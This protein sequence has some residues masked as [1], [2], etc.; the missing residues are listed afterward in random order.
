MV[1]TCPTKTFDEFEPEVKESTRTQKYKK[2]IL[3]APYEICIERARYFTQ[4]YKETEGLHPSLRAAKAIEKT[5]DN[6]TIYIL[7]E[8]LL[9]GNRSSKLVASVIPIERGEF[10][11][12][13]ELDLNNILK[14]EKQPF[15]ISKEEKRELLK[16]ILP[17]WRGKDFRSDKL[18][19]F[20]ENNVYLIPKLSLFSIFR[21]IKNFGIKALWKT[22][23]PL[24]KGRLLHFKRGIRE[25]AIN[26]PNLV[27]DVFDDQ[28]HLILGHDLVMPIGYKGVKEQAN[29]LKE[30]NPDKSA[31]YDAV[32]ICCDAVRRFAERFSSLAL[33]I[34][35]EETNS[36]RREELIQ[37]SNNMK[38]VPWNPPEHFYEAVQFIWFSQNI[39]LI[40]FGLG[41]IFSIGRPDQYLY[42]YYKRDLEE[43][44]ISREFALELVEE[45]LIKL[46]Y[47]L[48]ILP[49]Y[50]K[51]TASEL[52]GDNN[53]VAVGGV[54]SEGKDAAN[55]LS[56]IF[57]DAIGNIKS[58]T[59]SFSMRLNKNSTDEYL[60]KVA[61]VFSKTS[62]P[63]IYNDEIIISALM[64][65]GCSL[66][67]SRNYGIIGC[68]EPTSCGNTF[69]CT[70]G[71]DISLV[72]ILERVINNG[73]LRFMG[74]RTGLKTGKF[75]NF[76]SFEEILEAFKMQLAKNIEF[77]AKLVNIKD[78]VYMEKFH[79]PL[80]SILVKG[81]LEK[82]LDETQG[83]AK[84]NFG[85]I[86]ARGLATAADSL[87]AIKKAVFDWKWITLKELKK[88]LDKNF[89]KN[90]ALR[91]KLINKIP[92]YGND[93]DEA[94]EMAIIVAEIFSDLVMEQKN[95]RGGIFRPGFFSYGMNVVDGSLLG[96]TPNGR[97]AGQP[98]S[99]SMSPSN[100]VEKYGPTAII[101]SYA[102]I[103]HE[104]ISNGSALNI[105][106]NP[107]YFKNEERKKK[108]ISLLRSFIELG[109][110]HAQF[111]TIDNK[112]LKDAQV[113]PDNYW[114][115]V[116]RVSGYCAYFNDLGKPVQ[117]D[118]IQRTEFNT[119]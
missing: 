26:N 79:N 114:D 60:M 112:I 5:L 27:D 57:M 52:G 83:G 84:Y 71:N 13:F 118:I 18:I 76:K 95:I 35:D 80:I 59:N 72:G 48:L 106:L 45:L 40:A 70:A 36:A 25:L 50:A 7:P 107:A 41:G 97:Y 89:R 117:D 10:N 43:G 20:K 102:K 14:R 66:E 74:K 22:L 73:R 53:A 116:V 75:K 1:Y 54:D 32:I 113:N 61:D 58:M 69:G 12:V 86:T 108:F 21:R 64:K 11:V 51:N 47:N 96:A 16:E 31:F 81:C 103:N 37:I 101:R 65:T 68:V 8:E 100:N 109:A 30:Q 110:M 28:G 39:A 24:I 98:V 46:S 99:N 56:F 38:K 90:E 105:K 3:M 23:R 15:M 111:N 33:K 63:A 115:L 62:G 17:Y 4:A 93:D 88:V 85:S 44:R 77:I 29:R 19:E 9:V 42:P 87:L 49:S 6:A 94:D 92:K 119:I 104:K 91:Q 55:A 78:K 34:A 67:D 2:R 82:G